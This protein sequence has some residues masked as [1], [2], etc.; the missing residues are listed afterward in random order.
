MIFQNCNNILSFKSV[1]KISNL[2]QIV[3]YSLDFVNQYAIIIL[4]ASNLTFKEIAAMKVIFS[5]QEKELEKTRKRMDRLDLIIHEY[6][7]KNRK[8]KEYFA[9]RVGCAPSTLWRYCS[10][11]GC[12]KKIPLDILT[13]IFRIT[14]ISND[15][16]RF[17]MGL[18]RGITDEN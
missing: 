10:K 1:I 14:N 3:T 12:F 18:P 6:L 8:S 15:D 16:L 17:I 2:K 13:E 9:D 4:L 11:V 5:E 7:R